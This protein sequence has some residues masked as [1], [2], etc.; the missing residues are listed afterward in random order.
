MADAWERFRT[1]FNALVL[2]EMILK[3]HLGQYQ[4][5]N[6]LK[7]LKSRYAPF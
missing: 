3:S 2:A 7:G 1:L 6:Y 4:N 5:R